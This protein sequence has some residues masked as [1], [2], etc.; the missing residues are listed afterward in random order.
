MTVGPSVY[1]PGR[2]YM[3]DSRE[4]VLGPSLAM[5]AANTLRLT[6]AVIH[7]TV[8]ISSLGA[9]VTT[10]EAGKNIQL[11]IY[12]ASPTTAYPTTLVAKTGSMTTDATGSKTASITGGNVTL[13]PGLYWWT[14][15]TDGTAVAMVTGVTATLQGP[16]M[17]GSTTIGNVVGNAVTLMA[18]TTPDTFGTWTANISGN[19][20][21]EITNNR[22]AVVAFQVA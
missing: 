14:I 9:T 18:L 11:G 15:N 21:T 20:F 5:S 7:R 22:R 2:W 16:V 13:T 10:G 8:T 4:T 12:A 3:P 17:I 1:V 19:T 6:P